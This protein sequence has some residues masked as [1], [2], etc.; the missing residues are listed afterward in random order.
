MKKRGFIIYFLFLGLFF[1]PKSVFAQTYT[2]TAS[3]GRSAVMNTSSVYYY[4]DWK[5]LSTD[6]I[7]G[8]PV[9]YT[10]AFY[11][12]GSEYSFPITL[13]GDT[14][15]SGR[16]LIP[17]AANTIYS[18]QL[19]NGLNDSDMQFG[20][21]QNWGVY[22]INAVITSAVWDCESYL[23]QNFGIYHNLCYYDIKFNFSLPDALTGAY[24]LN[25]AVLNT[26]GQHSSYYY[27]DSTGSSIEFPVSASNSQYSSI[28][29]SLS[30]TSTG[31]SSG[32]NDTEEI[33][34]G[35]EEST[36]VIASQIEESYE[37]LVKSQEVCQLIDKSYIISDNSLFTSTGVIQSNNNFGITNYISIYN[38]SVNVID[39]NNNGYASY[40]FYRHDKTRIGC[41]NNN[42][43]S[44]NSPL[45][46]PNNAYYI[47]LSV[48]HTDNVP[49][50][51]ICQ[52][53][54]QALA[55]SVLDDT[56]DNFTGTGELSDIGG[57]IT[58]TTPVTDLLA[59]PIQ[60]LTAL[61][62]GVNGTC[63]TFN[64]GSLY[65]VGINLPCIAPELYLGS[66]LWNAIDLLFCGFMIYSIAQL[67]IHD[68][69]SISSAEDLFDETYTP[70][71]EKE[72]TRRSE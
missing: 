12:M 26:N 68:W 4:T 57:R 69:D 23:V 30:M 2:R 9:P 39:S 34:T 28:F 46:I 7:N 5:L 42:T 14:Y 53:G 63:S 6:S 41:Y 21:H 37:N 11:H 66:T 3:V 51:N 65:G 8:V 10:G 13:T 20:L 50:L 19:M 60:L 16:V 45:T 67:M 31:G 71:H 29:P 44:S 22:N 38:K 35:I 58:T 27:S 49:T 54:N 25:V 59:L 1:I 47:R 32:S 15:F 48:Q 43:M 62:N 52:N 33:L 36:Q 70:R 17:V 61:Y 56:I 72:R 40:C 64:L 18:Y 55:D 24:N